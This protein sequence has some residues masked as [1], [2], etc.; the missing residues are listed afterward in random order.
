[1]TNAL[2]E[3]IKPLQ[4]WRRAAMRLWRILKQALIH[5]RGPWRNFETVEYATLEWVDWFNNRR[6]RKPI[7]NMPPAEA[8]TQFFAAIEGL[9]IA[10]CLILIGLREN[11]PGSTRMEG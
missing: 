11:R 3:T 7:G 4:G 9:D 10:A 5:R 6:L 1:M 2:A 8:G